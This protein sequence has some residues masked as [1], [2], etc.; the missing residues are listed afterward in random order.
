[1]TSKDHD[2]KDSESDQSDT[3]SSDDI[4]LHE[5]LGL[6]A[7]LESKEEKGEKRVRRSEPSPQLPPPT[8]IHHLEPQCSMNLSDAPQP[9]Q[10]SIVTNPPSSVVLTEN[11][12]PE[13]VSQQALPKTK[14]R[15]GPFDYDESQL[16][17]INQDDLQKRHDGEEFIIKRP[18]ATANLPTSRSQVHTKVERT[19][20]Q[21]TYLLTESQD[22]LP[23]L[24]EKWAEGARKRMEGRKRYGFI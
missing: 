21:I 4:P 19:R 15:R 7:G 13:N 3:E 17:K 12:L 10:Q 9:A 5:L 24:E 6:S 20:H 11:K 18:T 14:K 8:K 1:M 23:M 16:I 2:I 22:K